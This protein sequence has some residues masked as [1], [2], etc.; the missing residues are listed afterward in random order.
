MKLKP[1]D[2]E[3]MP[4]HKKIELIQL[5]EEQQRRTEAANDKLADFSAY[6]WQR[7]FWAA[8]ATNYQRLLMAANQVGKS[9]CGA[10][11]TAYHLTGLYPDDWP[12]VKFAKPPLVWAFGLSSETI[13][14]NGQ[15]KL[16]GIL[17][18]DS[19]I[20]QGYV[21]SNL[22]DVSNIIRSSQVKGFAKEVFV[23]HVSG[24][25]SHLVFKS[26]EQRQHALMGPVVD[27]IWIDEEPR[28]P[29]IYPQC[30]TRTLNG[31][32]GKGG[33]VIMTFTPENG[34]TLLV[35]QFMQELQKGQY[36]LNVTWDD[37][38]H[39]TQERKE[40][41]LKAYPAH[42]RAM[43]TKGIPLMGAG[44]V[45]P[46]EESR[47][48]GYIPGIQRQGIPKWH[49]QLG[50]MDFGYGGEH[51]T[52]AAYLS[53]DA[54]KDIIYV[55]DGFKLSGDTATVIEIS[56]LMRKRPLWIPV[57]WPHDGES[58]KMSKDGSFKRIA[59]QYREEGINMLS[60]HATFEDGSNGVEAGLLEMETRMKTARLIIAPHLDEFFEEMRLYHRKDGKV[61]KERDD[62]I[63][64]VRYGM[65]MIRYA[66]REPIP[67]DYIETSGSGRGVMGY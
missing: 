14:S 4:R 55:H 12:G 34:V 36:L 20:T 25:W 58:K 3:S 42:Q 9:D 61:V 31:N 53:Y 30:L 15:F 43:R 5:I 26:Y 54:D 10:V 13:K 23:K 35:H 44:V 21:N 24:G 32:E 33:H 57:A 60:E 29:D 64:A 27:F 65:M 63:S 56:S 16:F 51:P 46:V 45:F 66:E 47:I 62:F 22:I 39:I 7:K 50:C 19:F 2:I 59:Q 6:P 41:M 52:A 17:Q 28:D 67:D 8:G 37:A 11:E 49:F 38:P 1:A 48:K 40:Q 18:D